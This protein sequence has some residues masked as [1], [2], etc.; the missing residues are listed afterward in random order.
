MTMT[1]H[2]FDDIPATDG[3]TYLRTLETDYVYRTLL[4]D[5]ETGKII[6]DTAD[7]QTWPKFYDLGWTKAELH[8]GHLSEWEGEYRDYVDTSRA[9]E[10]VDDAVNRL[11]WDHQAV[12]RFLNLQDWE[13]L[14][15][16]MQWD[17]IIDRLEDLGDD[18]GR[19][20]IEEAIATVMAEP[21]AQ[22]MDDATP[23]LGSS[24]P[25]PKFGFDGPPQPGLEPVKSATKPV[26][27][28]YRRLGPTR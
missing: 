19:D 5:Q 18:S 7:S 21:P 8:E 15:S 27:A 9:E 23:A 4:Q 22:K 24:Q 25:G 3:L 12:E 10:L 6:A 28:M 17:E 14:P 1:I 11:G 13:V 2:D 16:E 20:E 26:P